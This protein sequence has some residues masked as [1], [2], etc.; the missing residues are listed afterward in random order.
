MSSRRLARLGCGAL[1]GLALAGCVNLD[2]LGG[3]TQ[4]LAETV[5]RGTSGP[6]IALLDI[7][8]VISESRDESQL[9]LPPEESMVARV[10]EQL[11][12][13]RQDADVHALLLRIDSPGGSVTGS[14]ILYQELMRF[15]RE[16]GVPVV[17]HFLGVAASG[18]Y[19]VAMAADEVIAQPTA[20]TGSIGVIF[21]GV[22]VSGLMSKLGVADQTLKA[23]EQKDAGSWLRPMQP[24]ERAH[25][26]SVLDDMHARFKQVVAA[27]RSGLDARRIDG[28]ADGRIFSAGQAQSLGLVDALGDLEQAVAAAERRAGLKSS[29][30][31]VYHRPREY[32]HNLY[33]RAPVVPRALRVELVPS[34]PLAR[35][36]FLY[37]WAPGLP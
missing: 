18:A 9:L 20:V 33:S 19:Y 28:L 35:P 25:L 11:E 31:V 21:A 16:R 13:A 6:K 22:N 36:G 29:R 7:D 3:T 5:I 27:G 23:G 12:H 14:D 26:Q 8:G 34:L 4:P 17:A 30:V 37:L 1:A 32:R 2:L 24:A 10:R 15:K